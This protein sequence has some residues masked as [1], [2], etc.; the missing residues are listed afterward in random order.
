MKNTRH[1]GVI[2]EYDLHALSVRIGYG[3]IVFLCCLMV[4]VAVF[5]LI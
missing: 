3:F 4:L 2:R 1:T 5:P